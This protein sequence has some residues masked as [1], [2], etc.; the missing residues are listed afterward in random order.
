MHTGQENRSIHSLI[1]GIV[2]VAFTLTACASP[3]AMAPSNPPSIANTTR[4]PEPLIVQTESD[5]ATECDP[6]VRDDAAP[7]DDYGHALYTP[8]EET[9]TYQMVT[10][11]ND[12]NNLQIG[13]FRG[14]W[15]AA[16]PRHLKHIPKH[17]G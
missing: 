9:A 6:D 5:A 8:A 16:L 1:A 12:C 7:S 11:E 3:A 2:A 13:C 15:R 4:N 14:C 10:T 17:G